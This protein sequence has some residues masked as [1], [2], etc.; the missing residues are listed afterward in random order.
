[1]NFYFK[2]KYSEFDELFPK[3]KLQHFKDFPIQIAN[4]DLQ[5]KHIDKSELLLTL[6]KNFQKQLLKFQK[7]CERRFE[8]INFNKKLQDWYKLSYADF[9]KELA[10]QKIKLTLSEEADWADYFE[11]EKSKAVEIQSKIESTDQEIDQMVYELYG[12]NEEEIRI[13]ENG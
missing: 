4:T 6:K 7:T 1:M 2:N 11:Q 8:N 12:L 10:K 3:V 5:L 9:I 13:V